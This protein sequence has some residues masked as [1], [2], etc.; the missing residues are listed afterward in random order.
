MVSVRAGSWLKLFCRLSLGARFW[1]ILVSLKA[2]EPQGGPSSVMAGPSS[3]CI[4]GCLFG[5]GVL[6]SMYPMC[7]GWEV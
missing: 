7:R 2:P 6:A 1:H 5:L 4:A 3:F